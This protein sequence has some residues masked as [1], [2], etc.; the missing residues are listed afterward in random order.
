MSI[1]PAAPLSSAPAAV[2]SSPADTSDG[3]KE[4]AR[5][6]PQPIEQRIS[7]QPSFDL[8]D[9][10]APVSVPPTPVW[11]QRSRDSRMELLRLCDI[12]LSRSKFPAPARQATE[13]L[14]KKLLAVRRIVYPFRA[15]VGPAFQGLVRLDGDLDAQDILNDLD[16]LYRST[17]KEMT[18]ERVR[19]LGLGPGFDDL[20]LENRPL[21][22]LANVLRQVSG[23]LRP[24][25]GPA[26]R[27]VAITMEFI[28]AAVEAMLPPRI[29]SAL[30]EC[31]LCHRHTPDKICSRH[32]EG[33]RYITPP[34]QRARYLSAFERETDGLMA[35]IA[36][37]EA[38]FRAWGHR[39]AV[40]DLA[41]AD[42]QR[43]FDVLFPVEPMAGTPTLWKRVLETSHLQ[44][45]APDDA[46]DLKT[47]AS[48]WYSLPEVDDVLGVDRLAQ[49]LHGVFFKLLHDV[50]RYEAFV[51]SGGR[52][53]R[54][55]RKMYPPPTASQIRRA[56]RM[57]QAHASL[58]SISA[59][60]GVSV[61]RLRNLFQERGL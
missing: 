4:R 2:D 30:N 1:P 20:P 36:R 8:P 38:E 59:E 11:G 17:L 51:A 47:L 49:P 12:E 42:V 41:V 9:D 48:A 15:D 24:L 19:M 27:D 26:L 6:K 25:P 45:K 55:T 23:A 3:K 31:V 46:V 50:S 60:V 37:H 5:A 34:S 54:A 44:A 35:R 52:V 43:A 32:R 13:S 39:E 56:V 57:R 18:R 61:F 53:V 58:A 33:G 10:L 16:A 7:H 14:K 29:R 22:L 40:G 21:H 28:A